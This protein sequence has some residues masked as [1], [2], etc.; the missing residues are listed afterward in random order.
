[1]SHEPR[2]IV[3]DIPALT[4]I[5]DAVS[6]RS[7]SSTENPYPRWVNLISSKSKISGRVCDDVKLQLHAA[8]IKNV[9]APSI[10]IAGCGTGQ[11]SIEAASRFANSTVTAIDVSRASLAY[12][13]RKASELGFSNLE[14]MQAD[15]LKLGMLNKRFDI[16]ESSGVLHHMSDPLTGWRVLVDLLNTGGLM[17]IGLYSELARRYIVK[18]Q[19]EI[20]STE[21]D[22][23]DSTI[24]QL[25]HVLAGSNDEHHQ[26]LSNIN[27]FYTVNMFKVGFTCTRAPFYAPRG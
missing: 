24:R 12:S 21:S 8:D 26:R 4:T 23:T 10:L 19:Q 11:H 14:Y 2:V 5:D 15:I 22:A 25:R 1:M 9:L 16:V 27:D 17:K 18:V 3:E 6:L 7:E 20:A 13:K